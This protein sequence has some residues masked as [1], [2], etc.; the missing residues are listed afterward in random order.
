M[1]GQWTTNH[2][3]QKS[4]VF[5]I[6]KERYL[7]IEAVLGLLGLLGVELQVGISVLEVRGADLVETFVF[8]RRKNAG[9]LI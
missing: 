8:A 2:L 4:C 7:H 1:I 9:I 3:S 6:F 5:V